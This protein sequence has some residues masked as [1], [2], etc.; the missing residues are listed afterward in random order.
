VEVQIEAVVDVVDDW[1]NLL[2][3]AV[4]PGDLLTGRYMYD[5]MAADTSPSLFYGA[6][7]QAGP[8]YGIT[9]EGGGLTF[10]TD[11]DT[12]IPS[13]RVAVGNN[14]YEQDSFQILSNHNFP[15]STGR[16]VK[17]ISW[18]LDD[19]TQ[20]ALTEV[21]P[22]LTAPD[23]AR[24]QSTFGL[25][26]Q[27]DDGTDYSAEY[28]E[29][30]ALV[31]RAELVGLAVGSGSVQESHSGDVSLPVPITLSDPHT[32]A[33]TVAWTTVDGTA[34]A[35]SDYV[36]Q[37]G[38]LTFLPG[39]TAHEV[40]L[41][42]KSDG[43]VE[44]A[45]AFGLRITTADWAGIATQ[46]G[47]V[48]IHDAALPI[49]SVPDAS[50][51][52]VDSGTVAARFTVTLSVPPTS[53][54]TVSFTTVP[55]TA[56]AGPDF[57]AKTGTLTFA[58]GSTKKVLGI[59]VK[60]DVKDEDDETFTLQLS[61]PGGATLSDD[62]ALGRILDNDPPP[63]MSVGDAE[64]TEGDSGTVNAVFTVRLPAPSGR[65][66][67]VAYATRNGSATAPADFRSKSGTLVFNPGILTRTT[68]VAVKGDVRAEGDEGFTLELSAPVNA[69]VGTGVGTG[70][71]RDNE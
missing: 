43:D 63:V 42:V 48:T 8:Q 11:P 7:E 21:V 2:G 1:G 6:Y 3:G 14:Y 65:T 66:V 33:I 9:V 41:T 13:Y 30:R 37:A 31:T 12:P 60:G 69:T 50:V 19:P 52:E 10:A 34:Q 23:L 67:S 17:T 26:L 24:W 18:Q 22:P 55:G 4:Q 29:I 61:A 35:G 16:S 47:T 32:H 39:E 15:L 27:G 54:V 44:P 5:P 51:S 46:V 25:S 40:P 71:I 36:P 56:Q 64:V 62:S 49:L 58:P 68:T 53:P 28:Y 57:A 20:T 59:N 38:S 70:T 45:E